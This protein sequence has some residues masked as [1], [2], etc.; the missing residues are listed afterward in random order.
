MI[1]QKIEIE[2]FFCFVGK[3]ILV[4]EKGLNIIS[5]KN[6]GGKSQLFN[7]FN[8]VFFNSVYVDKDENS[9]KKEWKNA[10]NII[11]IPNNVEYTSELN[12]KIKTSVKISLITEFHENES[13]EGEQIEYCFEKEMIFEKGD[14]GVFPISKPELQIWYA[15]EGETFYIEKGEQTW[16][17]NK[18][19]PSSIR[20]FMWF[21]G[22]TVDDL[23][24][25]SNPSTLNYAIQE[26][27]YFPIYE[28]MYNIIKKAEETILSKIDKELAIARKL[29]KEQEQI[30]AQIAQ[31]RKDIGNCENNII[32]KREELDNLS[33]AIFAEESKLKG[34]DKY[35]ELKNKLFKLDYDIKSIN[36][37]IDYQSGVSKES[38]ISKWMLNK[39]E[40]LIHASAKNL[41]LLSLEIKDLQ[42]SENPVPI[43][44]PGP[45]YVQK[46]LDDHICY[47]CERKVEEGTEAFEALKNRMEDF[48]ANQ[49]L[50]SLSV[51]YTE[52]NKFMR[53]VLIEL[54][55][56]TE[57]VEENESRFNELLE[58]RKKLISEKNSLMSDSGVEKNVIITGS[59]TAEQILNKI[60]SLNASRGTTERK[61]AGY[62]NEKINLE[63]SLEVVLSK[64]RTDIGENNE[65]VEVRAGKYIEVI[66]N[67]LLRLKNSA[68]SKLITEI[69]EESNLLYSKYL[70]GKTAGEI[71]IDKGVR[72]I[73]R[74]TKKLLT[75]LNTA[76]LI[77]QK[78]AVANSF[79]SLSQKK[80][81]RSFPLLADAPTSDLDPDNT[82]FLTENL[83]NSFDQ[84][85][86][87]SKDYTKLDENEIKS[88]MEK[89]K[90][91]KFY[92]L[93]N[94]LIDPN[95]EDSRI[96]KKTYVKIIK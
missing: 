66:N 3:E 45:E 18:I 77:A 40:P 42:K 16:F 93:I 59:S 2:N 57:E 64:K 5:A 76:E 9:S 25:F 32:I 7:A 67:T 6:S 62:E 15:K 90:V 4:F 91:V 53:N 19:F 54:P 20:K 26:I 31:I 52:L 79:L 85:I 71:E 27:S 81:N 1:I 29:T 11:T 50:K 70:G 38:F 80:L 68:L 56:I 12:Q 47:I 75:N 34:Y 88:L 60:N 24:D 21:Q 72:I 43:T 8:W 13:E 73:D 83:H 36:D 86:L 37:K 39:C 69:T 17:L 48:K 23:Y 35:T 74:S 51:N 46:M 44:L 96:N 78:L 33:Q 14:N 58:K 92:E 22:E 28:N 82:L 65:I 87:M 63:K 10:D 61:L 95:G 41:E 89:A 84:I 49:I 94:D 30:I 55:N